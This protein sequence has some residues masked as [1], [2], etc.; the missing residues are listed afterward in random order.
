MVPDSSPLIAFK[1]P[2]F[3]DPASFAFRS[4][5]ETFRRADL[6]GLFAFLDVF[7]IRHLLIAASI[8][9][10][11]RICQE[12]FPFRWHFHSPAFR[13]EGIFDRI[14]GEDILEAALPVASTHRA[15]A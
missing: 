6:A 15:E 5:M 11:S 14:P 4:L 9:P 10:A 8:G 12:N 7:A 1:T 3:T 13:E 2:P